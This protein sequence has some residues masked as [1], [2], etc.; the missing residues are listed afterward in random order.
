M[1]GEGS[2]EDFIVT[3]SDVDDDDWQDKVN[4]SAFAKCLHALHP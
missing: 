2:I 3:D 1:V 4:L